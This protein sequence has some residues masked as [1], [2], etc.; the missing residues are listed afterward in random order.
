MRPVAEPYR[1]L[2]DGREVSACLLDAGGAL[3]V[4][5]MTYGATV[6]SIETT[7][8]DGRWGEVVL[9]FDD[10]RRYEVHDAYFGA[11]IGRHA[12]RIAGGR[13]TLDGT[14]YL[15]GCNN[16]VNHLH[17]GARGFDKRLWTA[18]P[19]DV[20]EGSAI[21]LAYASA[22]MEEGYPGALQVQVVYTV[23]RTNELCIDY[24][25]QSDRPTVVNLT[26]HT[27][28]NLAGSGTVLGHELQIPGSRYLPVDATLIP[29][30][31]LAEVD[32][33][34][35]DF[36]QPRLIGERLQA[37]HQQLQRA[38]GYDHN[39]VLDQDGTDALRP[40]AVL[41]DPS[42]G[43]RVWVSTT[44]PG[45]QF[46]SGNFLDGSLVGR[47]GQRYERH[48]GLCLETQHFPDSPN[49]PQFPTTRLD[50]QAIYTQRTVYRFDTLSR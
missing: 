47:N 12:N 36:R 23:T 49:Q 46:Y 29:T 19:L 14:Q 2:K 33:T 11:V 10:P 31:E 16:G 41:H 40:A 26:N 50:P 44:Q 21:E 37:N 32:G 15:L 25:A 6:V 20:P 9:G 48:A 17:G 34:P 13:F 35:M 1:T 18:Q 43:R 38:G 42:S 28:F 45:L 27:Y 24:R 22:H 7:D 30:G 5:V 39:W 8:R 4:R 3:R